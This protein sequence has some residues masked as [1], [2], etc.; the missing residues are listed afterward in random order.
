MQAE[1]VETVSPI[2]AFATAADIAQLLLSGNVRR[3]LQLDQLCR[4]AGCASFGLWLISLKFLLCLVVI[5]LLLLDFS[6]TLQ[7]NT[8]AI[9][10][11]YKRRTKHRHQHL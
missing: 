3:R 4:P 11:P 10:S 1:L 2:P 8:A 7:K 5:A 9:I 6:H